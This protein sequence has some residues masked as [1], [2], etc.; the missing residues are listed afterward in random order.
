MTT[1]VVPDR[2]RAALHQAS[3]IRPAVGGFPHFAQALRAA[4]LVR[5]D[6]DLASGGSVYHLR[7]EAVS[8]TWGPLGGGLS[9][10]PAWNQIAVIAAIRTDQAGQS[11]F[12][13]FLAACWDGGVIR[14]SVDL[15]ERTCTYHGA[16]RNTYL[17]RYPAVEIAA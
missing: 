14:F 5:I 16:A 1:A 12:P 9:P 10:V 7:E 8:D 17:E 3:S 13:E 11:T 4:G 2:V 15:L 6:T